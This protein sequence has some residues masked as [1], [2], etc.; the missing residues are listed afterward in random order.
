M[1]GHTS[2]FPVLLSP[3]KHEALWTFLDGDNLDQIIW[4]G[5]LPLSNNK[6]ATLYGRVTHI[7]FSTSSDFWACVWSSAYSWSSPW[8]LS[9]L[10][11]LTVARRGVRHVPELV[12]PPD[13]GKP[14]WTPPPR[15][16]HCTARWR[17]DPKNANKELNTCYLVH[18]FSWSCS[19]IKHVTFRMENMA[20]YGWNDI[21]AGV[22]SS[23]RNNNKA[24]FERPLE[25]FLPHPQYYF[26]YQA[27]WSHKHH[28]IL[29]WIL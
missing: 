24:T 12:S 11:G 7:K 29:M 17:N 4:G 26:Y 10:P 15:Y 19:V 23:H 6:T 20:E 13:S 22:M 21:K 2:T 1:T 9:D 28:H 14:T 16:R 18:V 5:R 3:E 8:S 27:D 25:D